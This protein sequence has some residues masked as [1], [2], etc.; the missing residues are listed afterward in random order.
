MKQKFLTLILLLT[1][2]IGTLC[3]S[4]TSVDGIYYNF[5][6]TN[7]TATVTCRGSYGNEYSNEYSGSIVIP[8]SVTYNGV[9]YCVTKIDGDSFYKCTA[10]ESVIIP[11]SVVEIATGAFNESSLKYVKIGDGLKVIGNQ[12]FNCPLDTVVLGRNVQSIGNYN[13]YSMPVFIF[14]SATPPFLKH[15]Y[16]NTTYLYL[17]GMST[18]AKCATCIIPCGS[19]EAYLASRWT[20]VANIFIENSEYSVNVLSS[21]KSEGIAKIVQKDCEEV[22]IEAKPQEGY[23]FVKWSDGST[24]SKRNI[25]LTQDS[26]LTAYFAKEGYTIHVYQDCNTTIE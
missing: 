6:N 4:N 25:I 22:I 24:T 14:N 1:V 9:C 8:D 11:N 23:T 18:Q 15:N 19:K 12:V 26:T 13:F 16:I 20:N 2:C 7:L 10:L 17:G 3:A 5:D 21:N